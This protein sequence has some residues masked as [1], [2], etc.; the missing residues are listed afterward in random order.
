RL[1]EF[2][3]K[4][5]LISKQRIDKI[6]NKQKEVKLEIENLQKL[7]H[8]NK[9][10]AKILKQPGMSYNRVKALDPRVKN[11][12]EDIAKQVEIEIKYE[13]YIQRE[14][15]LIQRLK[16]L[17]NKEISTQL[18]YEKIEGLKKESREK[19]LEIKPRSIGQAMRISGITSSDIALVL[20]H[21]EKKSKI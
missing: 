21:I 4:F 9:S 2:A 13:G 18:S 1:G 14:K 11:L 15:V 16:K 12:T 17:E 20:L 19:L 6:R 5:G 8:A 10:L 7:R 3:Y